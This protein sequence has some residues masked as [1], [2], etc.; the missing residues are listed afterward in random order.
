MSTF[1]VSKRLFSSVTEVPVGVVFGCFGNPMKANIGIVCQCMATPESH[2]ANYKKYLDH[3]K[4]YRR[5]GLVR[6]E[7]S[8][9]G[10]YEFSY[11]IKV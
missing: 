4:N 9:V 11:D 7:S 8:I 1:R 3:I 5:L 10:Y 6:K 2:L